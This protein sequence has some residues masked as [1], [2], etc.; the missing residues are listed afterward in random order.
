MWHLWKEWR[1]CFMCVCR[2]ACRSII[3][4][5]MEHHFTVSLIQCVVAFHTVVQHSHYYSNKLGNMCIV[6][7]R[8]CL[9]VSET[10]RHTEMVWGLLHA[11]GWVWNM[12][13][14]H[15]FLSTETLVNCL[16]FLSDCNPNSNVLT[17]FIEASHY[18]TISECRWESIVTCLA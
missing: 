18:K 17:D 11:T 2:T 12:S 3:M 7:L 4:F 5:A 15:I 6:S 10:V 8:L 13:L 9:F 16:L 1:L 14:M